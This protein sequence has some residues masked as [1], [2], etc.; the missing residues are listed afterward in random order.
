MCSCL[1]FR[2]EVQC[3]S[4]CAVHVASAEEVHKFPVWV[5]V[6]RLFRMF[7]ARARPAPY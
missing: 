3:L 7:T 1:F 6:L 2:F 5:L 4:V